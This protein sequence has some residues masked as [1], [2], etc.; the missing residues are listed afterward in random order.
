MLLKKFART[1]AKILTKVQMK[2]ALILFL[3]FLIFVASG[4]HESYPDEF[5][6]IVGGKF[7]LQ[8]KI[9][10]RDW[11][12][13]HQPGAYVWAALLLLISGISFVRFRLLLSVSFFVLNILGYWL[14]KK[15]LSKKRDLSFYAIFLFVLSLA[16]TYYWGQ[17][18]L[19]DTLAAYL[20][21]PAYAILLL[22]DYYQE[23]FETSDLVI[24]SLFA[25]GVWLTS[26][27][28]IYLL[29][30]LYVY[31]AYLY[32]K[33]ISISLKGT[34]KKL[35]GLMAILG[36]PFVLFFVYLLISGSL[37]EWYFANLTYNQEFYIYNYPRTPGAGFNPL[38]YAIIIA[39]TF[40][41]NFFPLLTG[42]K[43]FAFGDPGNITLAV[44]NGAF[45]ILLLIK[46]RFTFIGPFLTVLVYSMTRS[47]PF[48]IGETDYQAIV[49]VLTSLFIGFFTFFA[50]KDGLNKKDF[51]EAG[52]A[53]ASVLMVLLGVYLFFDSF[54]IGL[55]FFQKFYA[56]YM[57]TAPLIYDRPQAAPLVNRLTRENE[58]AWVGPFEF[59]EI[60]YLKSKI[61]SKHH[62]FL[63]HAVESDKMRNEILSD[64]DKHRAK[65]IVFDRGYAPWGGD[66][67]SFNYFFTDF[68]DENYFRIFKLS[69]GEENFDY[70]WKI[71]RTKDFDIDGDFN[72][73]KNR[74]EEILKELLDLDL[75]E[76]VK[77]S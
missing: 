11:F 6:S 7:I 29:A 40:F 43:N 3:L 74:K 62:W 36:G 18:L 63:N 19:A 69:E 30:G 34:G 77:K 26:M 33:P 71:G 48:A 50:L 58:Y 21:I 32:A 35:I 46:K 31:A 24:F 23:K 17:M 1:F 22:K 13:H 52:K 60:F 47:N 9:P 14:I 59:E 44:A 64:F 28:Y 72:F 51:S 2:P 76:K 49:Y 45:F 42:V 27:T 37:K 75:I 10:Y 25:F 8:G 56:K 73:D 57:G 55:K 39:H 15:R 5:D 70:R 66:A 53:A 12:Q 65:V 61:P 16:A 68:L 54:F 38:R 67:H 41:N 4:L 20:I